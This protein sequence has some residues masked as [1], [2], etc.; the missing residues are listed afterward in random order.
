MVDIGRA[1]DRGGSGG[2]WAWGLGGKGRIVWEFTI[3]KEGKPVRE[4]LDV[5]RGGSL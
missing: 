2:F 5:E 3:L 4:D 1:P